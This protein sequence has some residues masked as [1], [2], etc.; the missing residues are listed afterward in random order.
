VTKIRE[1][2]AL[3]ILRVFAALPQSVIRAFAR[4]LTF[5]AWRSNGR[6]RRVTDRNLAICFPQLPRDERHRLARA[7]LYELSVSIFDLGRTWTWRPERLEQEIS[8]VTGCDDFHA[9]VGDDHGTI[10]LFPHLGNWELLNLALSKRYAMTGL[11]QE[12]PT[13]VFADLI[14][15]KRQRSGTTVVPIGTPGLRTLLRT[16]RSGGIVIVLPDQV[17]PQEFGEFAPFFGEPTLTM[18]LVT[19]LIGRTGAKAL[20][21]YCKRVPGGKYELVFRA[22]DDAIYDA[23]SAIAV[24]ALNKS[25]ERCVLDCP[26]QYQWYYK[27]FKFLPNLQKRDYDSIT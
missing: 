9:A 13:T 25:I 4:I 5:L 17:P 20:C 7:C 1:W 24:A 21:A 2:P 23:D 8:K 14:R 22:A 11:Y 26:E 16:L 12:P 10:L 19:N 27:R 6:L 15:R 3:A 18:T